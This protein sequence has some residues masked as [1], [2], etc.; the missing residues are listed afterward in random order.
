MS[1]YRLRAYWYLLISTL[2]WGLASVVIKATLTEI[3]PLP[4]LT[5]R[6]LLSSL[7]AVFF[8]GRIITLIKKHAEDSLE[9]ILHSL[10]SSTI[11]LGLLFWGLER[12]TVLDLA[13]ITLV[14]PLLTELAGVIFLGEHF[15][16]REKIGT[17]VA[18]VGTVFTIFEPLI[19]DGNGWGSFLGNA[20]IF[21]YLI[22][23]I[24]SVIILK[25]L[26]RKD[27]DITALTNLSFVIAF[28]AFLPF[29][30]LFANIDTVTG[31]INLP[32]KYHLGV[33]YMAFFSGTVAY[34]FR[35]KGQK[36]IEVGEAGLFSYLT[37][38][39]SALLAVIFLKEKVTIGFLIGAI[40]VTAG[41]VYAEIK[42]RVASRKLS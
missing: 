35:N 32:L 27:I 5:Y 36:T 25:R 13:V 40:I 39:V 9:I 38:V 37:Q 29:F 21:L 23:D 1:K 12:S 18:I 22:F 17:L 15:T 34:F 41:V 10:F 7:I 20:L 3:A 30:I 31:L 6:F 4:F 16:K 24:A 42:P 14:A 33:M 26:L 11:S 8:A 19:N 28:L 2:I